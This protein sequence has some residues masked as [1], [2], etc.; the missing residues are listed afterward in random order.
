MTII[1]VVVALL[2]M[3]LAFVVIGR[4]TGAKIA[5]TEGLEYQNNLRAADSFMYNIYQD[6]H[7]CVD[8]TEEHTGA[9][10]DAV[11]KLTFNMGTNGI[12]IYEYRVKDS[13]CYLNNVP[14]FT[15]RAFV[16]N[17]NEQFLYVSV[18]LDNGQRLE[19]QVY[20]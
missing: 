14:S 16:V 13:T 19:Y 18:Q 5:Q 12:H 9:G 17:G 6:Y 11:T 7:Q 2:L 20:R 15:C 1:E 3:G 4:L 10:E 8:Y